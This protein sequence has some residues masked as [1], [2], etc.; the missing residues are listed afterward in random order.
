MLP[1]PD[2]CSCWCVTLRVGDMALVCSFVKLKF[3][4]KLKHG[5]AV[6]HSFDHF[7]LFSLVFC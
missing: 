5:V 3:K 6:V 2:D 1:V 7:P 4:T